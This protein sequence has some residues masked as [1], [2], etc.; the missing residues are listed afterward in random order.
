M[1]CPCL[2][3]HGSF[4]HMKSNGVHHLLFLQRSLDSR[5]TWWQKLQEPYRRAS[6]SKQLVH[7]TRVANRVLTNLE[8]SK[9]FEIRSLS[10]WVVYK[11]VQIFKKQTRTQKCQGPWNPISKKATPKMNRLCFEPNPTWSKPEIMSKKFFKKTFLSFHDPHFC[12]ST[13]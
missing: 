8:F 5:T 3:T 7:T 4:W 12:G 13:R 6:C 10:L 2:P 9:V 11:N 1:F